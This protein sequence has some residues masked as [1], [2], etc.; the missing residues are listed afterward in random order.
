MKMTSTK[1]NHTSKLAILDSYNYV[2]LTS[3]SDHQLSDIF[4]FFQSQYDPSLSLEDIK[5]IIDNEGDIRKSSAQELIKETLVNYVIRWYMINPLMDVSLLVNISNHFNSIFNRIILDVNTIQQRKSLSS[6]YGFDF[7][8]SFKDESARILQSSSK[9]SPNNV[10]YLSD[11]VLNLNFKVTLS[12][13]LMTN[14]NGSEFLNP[15]FITN[16]PNDSNNYYPSGLINHYQLISYLERINLKFIKENRKI[17]LFLESKNHLLEKYLFSNIELIYINPKF[18]HNSYHQPH[19]CIKFPDSFGLNDWFKFHLSNNIPTESINEENIDT[20]LSSVLKKYHECTNK[21]LYDA[22]YY[23]FNQLNLLKS[24]LTSYSNVSI[25]L[26]KFVVKDDVLKIANE[27]IVSSTAPNYIYSIKD[28]Y[29]IILKLLKWEKGNNHTDIDQTINESDED[30]ILNF[31]IKDVYPYL[32]FN[33]S[34]TLNTFHSFLNEFINHHINDSNPLIQ[35]KNHDQTSSMLLKYESQHLGP[36]TEALEIEHQIK[37]LINAGQPSPITATTSSTP[38]KRIRSLLGDSSTSP[39][40]KKAKT[41]E[42]LNKD[43]SIVVDAE[44]SNGKFKKAMFSDDDSDSNDDSFALKVR[45]SKNTSLSEKTSDTSVDVKQ[46]GHGNGIVNGKQEKSKVEKVQNGNVVKPTE[47]EVEKESVEGEKEEE[48][49]KEE[50]QDDKMEIDEAPIAESNGHTEEKKDNSKSNND[51]FNKAFETELKAKPITPSQSINRRLSSDNNK[52]GTTESS[53][54]EES[55]DES[56]DSESE[57]DSE[58]ESEDHEKSKRKSVLVSQTPSPAQLVKTKPMMKPVP[59]KSN[60]I[61]E[62]KS[63]D[64]VIKPT[65]IENGNKKDG[66]DKIELS[67][68]TT[69]KR[70]ALTRNLSSLD[71][72]RLPSTTIETKDARPKSGPAASKPKFFAH[73][74]EDDS[75][76]DS[77]SE[78]SDDESE[79][80]KGADDDDDTPSKVALINKFNKLSKTKVEP[81]VS[82]PMVNKVTSF[83][84]TTKSPFTESQ[85]LHSSEFEESSSSDSSDSDSEDNS[86]SDSDSDD[87]KKVEA[88]K[89]EAKKVEVNK[90]EEKVE[91]EEDKEENDDDEDDEEEDDAEEEDGDEEEEGEEETEEEKV[92]Q[93]EEKVEDKVEEK[94]EVIP[95]TPTKRS[96]RSTQKPVNIT[97]STPKIATSIPKANTTVSKADTSIKVNGSKANTSINANPPIKANTSSV[98]KVNTS[99]SNSPS[100]VSTLSMKMKKSNARKRTSNRLLDKINKSNVSSVGYVK[101]KSSPKKVVKKIEFS[102]NSE[103]DDN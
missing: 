1:L 71:S 87:E 83:T 11:I 61:I 34:S 22:L 58:N 26:D 93:E 69:S 55:D 5:T 75:E 12:L 10:F 37:Q 99:I 102:S 47:H 29:Y 42:L 49:E 80:D 4:A 91:E 89:V 63:S 45:S 101:N 85:D 74:E 59:V 6:N 43:K 70:Q 81:K 50:D 68:Q 84:S 52:S 73:L 48:D 100:N 67:S 64:E 78:S 9:Y 72:L 40:V 18:E 76:S 8:A 53:S 33:E 25:P 79:D 103:D 86:D 39:T 97:T 30:K 27:S 54:E 35:S 13:S 28:I 56:S 17:V 92:Q 14:I 7:N 57:D 95:A 41:L 60:L 66:D 36:L 65:N 51:V 32:L 38:A 77:E 23:E 24:N 2:S 31:L 96:L 21:L 3:P 44:S 15:M 19:K 94:E 88:K 98:A 62:N 90:V 20:I 82:T 16:I 46:N